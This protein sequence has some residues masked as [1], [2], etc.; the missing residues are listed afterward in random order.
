MWPVRAVLAGQEGSF[1]SLAGVVNRRLPRT[2]LFRPCDE[3]GRHAPCIGAGFAVYYN[4]RQFRPCGKGV[5]LAFQ[6]PLRLV[7]VKNTPKSEN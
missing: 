2:G 5:G 6:N 7:S 3:L 1:E 4:R